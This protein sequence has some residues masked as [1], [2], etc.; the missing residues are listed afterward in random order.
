MI[1]N[2]RL[3]YRFHKYND[4]QVYKNGVDLM[5]VN[6]CGYSVVFSISVLIS[7]YCFEKIM[8]IR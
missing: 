5:L 4:T 2:Y 1:F 8:T 6:V 7:N 3:T